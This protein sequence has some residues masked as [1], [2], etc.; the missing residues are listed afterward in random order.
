MEGDFAKVSAN[1]NNIKYKNMIQR[2]KELYK[3]NIDLRSEFERDYTRIIH[4]T[5]YRR[6]K[7]KTQVFFSPESDHVCT[8]IEHVT[9]V[10][11]I[12][13]TIAKYL[14]LNTEL[15]RAISTGHDL[16]HSPFGHQ[17]EKI[18]SE[19]C[20]RDLGKKFW[21][22]QN[23]LNFVDKIELL[24]DREGYKQNMNLTYAVRDG[25]ISHCG[26]VDQNAIKP[27]EEFID[28]NEYKRPN[29]YAPYTWEGC[30]V[31][32]ADKISYIGRDIEDAIRLG[33]LDNN[34]DELYNIL[35]FSQTEK[36]NNSAIINKLV[37]DLALNSSVEKGIC[38]SKE[39]LEIMDRI[40]AFNYKNIY[41][42]ERLKSASRYFE[43]VINE[44]YDKLAGLY[45]KENTLER[46]KN[47]SKIYP[48]FINI[49][50]DWLQSYCN[51]T[52]RSNMNLKNKVVFDMARQEDYNEAIVYF[53]SGMTDKFV[54]DIY[55]E[56]I[57]F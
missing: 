27:R 41:F 45:E 35:N 30:V 31:K 49:F 33:I 48:K 6:L 1:E 24:E 36:I 21:H 18:L 43:L 53:I 44:I 47:E 54:L 8:R 7:H 37:L 40:K 4:S 10:D 23:G 42:N 26:E 57:S 3:D 11:S 56:I 12:S 38:F 9:H 13:Y 34:L 15:T 19:I 50:I 14:G 16:G 28:L 39:A 22:E 25:I 32:V 29:Q 46:L 17:G 55:R 52:D 20:E 2:E 5:A 51:L